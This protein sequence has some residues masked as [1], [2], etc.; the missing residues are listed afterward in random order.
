MDDLARELGMSKKTIYAHFPSKEWLLEAVLL[1]KSL[2]IEKDLE[3]ITSESSSDFLAAV[4]QLLE[5]MQE[6]LGELRPPFLRDMQREGPE[7]FKR[8]ETRRRDLLHHYFGKLVE[9]GRK[10]GIVRNDI[11]TALVIEILLATT[12]AIMNPPKLAELGLTPKQGFSAMMKV[13]LEGVITERGR[14][15]S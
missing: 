14:S 11:P 2:D 1:Y 15:K 10:G 12:Q 9:E 7:T 8:V 6:H 4:H 13:I 5:R 3:L